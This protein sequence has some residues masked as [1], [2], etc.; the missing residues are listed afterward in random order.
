MDR[1]IHG[2]NPEATNTQRFIYQNLCHCDT[3]CG[4]DIKVDPLVYVCKFITLY[5]KIHSICG[6]LEIKGMRGSFLGFLEA[7]VQLYNREK[8]F[9]IKEFD[10]IFLI[11]PCNQRR[12]S[13]R[14]RTRHV[15][16]TRWNLFSISLGF[17]YLFAIFSFES[18]SFQCILSSLVFHIS[19]KKENCRLMNKDLDHWETK[20]YGNQGKRYVVT[21]H[22][23]L[24]L[25]QMTIFSIPS[26]GKDG[27]NLGVL[28]GK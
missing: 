15:A 8:T 7:I 25:C 5:V 12:H 22:T 28:K 24:Q 23:I 9:E 4:C 20:C 21:W 2:F 14:S 19:F 13:I 17:I 26:I 3:M 10:A 27:C 6:L 18:Q 1:N 16:H 11:F